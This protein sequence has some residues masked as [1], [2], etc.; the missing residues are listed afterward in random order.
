LAKTHDT[1]TLVP[2]AG[3]A[4]GWADPFMTGAGLGLSSTDQA[5]VERCMR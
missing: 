2:A 4:A 3:Q 5:L 1:H